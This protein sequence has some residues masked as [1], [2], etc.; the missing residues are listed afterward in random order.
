[1]RINIENFKELIKKSTV[2]FSIETLQLKFG[3]GKIKSNMISSD[4]N[5]ISIINV[6]NNVIDTND[7][8]DF[9]F[10]DPSQSVIPYL[11]LFDNE[12]VNVRLYENRITLVD[13]QQR[14]NIGFC[15]P[16]IINLLGTNSIQENIDWFFNM[17]ID[18]NF[19]NIF[20][21]IRKIG[22]RFGKVYFDV[23]DGKIY[24]ETSDKTNQYSNGLKFELSN[25]EKDDLTLSFD[26]KNMVNLINVIGE[27]NNFTLNLTYKEEQELGMLYT[28][29]NDN[30]EK[31]CLLSK[32]L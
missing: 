6:D 10:S 30:S 24:I 13:G 3:G 2:N 25:C 14:S 28:K 20:K 12:T 17:E 1:V 26:Y 29:L 7:E 15:S 9:N 4:G 16:L 11:N 32:E 18:E 22:A 5:T 23:K 21:K 8:I 27:R 19:K 31:Y